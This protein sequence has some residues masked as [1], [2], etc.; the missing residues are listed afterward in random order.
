MDN[1]FIHNAGYSTYFSLILS[2]EYMN[3][4]RLSAGGIQYARNKL[5]KLGLIEKHNNVWKIVDPVFGC[6]LAGY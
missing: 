6:W 2:T 1:P 4:H 5:E 3:R